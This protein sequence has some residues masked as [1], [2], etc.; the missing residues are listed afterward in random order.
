[1]GIVQKD[2]FRT[3]VISYVGI[4]LGYVNKGLLFLIILTTEQIGLVNLLVTVGALFAQFANLGT[5]Y[6]TWKFFPYFRNEDKK[7]HGFLPFILSIVWV[8]ILLCTLVFILFRHEVQAMY[9]ENSAA[10]STYYFMV[11]PIGIS[12]VLYLVVEMYLRAL[13]KNTLAVFALEI[14]LR[15]SLTVLLGLLYTKVIDFNWFVILQS[16]SYVVPVSIVAVYL[17]YLGVC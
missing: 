6:S 10:F 15:L 16:I 5:I 7:H 14:G 17:I 3:M 1:M 8:G 11:L 9:A 4:V 13:Y 12:T 2:A